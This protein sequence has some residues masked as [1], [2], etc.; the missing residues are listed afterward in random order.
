MLSLK[1][2]KIL[3]HQIKLFKRIIFTSWRKEFIATAN[4]VIRAGGNPIFCDIERSTGCL[5]PEDILKKIK[6]KTSGIIFVPMFGV[7]PDSI[8]KIK[9][10]C[11]KNKFFLMEDAAHA[12]GASIKNIKARNL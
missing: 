4:A 2:L 1:S 3:I 6:K 10:I 9:K 12:H 7:M 11:K 8:L 5:D